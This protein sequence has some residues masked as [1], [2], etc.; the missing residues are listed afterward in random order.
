MW[1]LL[2]PEWEAEPGT[3]EGPF[4]CSPFPG[5]APTCGLGLRRHK[6]HLVNDGRINGTAHQREGQLEV[7]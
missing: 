1:P 4:S 3:S 7:L 5:Q 6:K 2:Q